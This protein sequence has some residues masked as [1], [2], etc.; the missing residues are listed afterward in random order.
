MAP[1][2]GFPG[3]SSAVTGWP[4][5][6]PDTPVSEVVDGPPAIPPG[7]TATVQPSA[8]RR[9][10]L[11]SDQRIL[12][13]FRQEIRLQGVVGEEKLAATVYLAMTSRLLDDPT[14]L[15]VKG[16]SSS[17]KSFTVQ[18]TA[19][20]FPRSAL[21]EMTAMSERALVY[22]KEPFAHRTIVLYEATA[23][24][25][26]AEKESNLTAYFVRS[27]LS[28]GH[29]EYPVT[30]RDKEGGWTTKTIT[31][32]GPT[33]L[34]V[35]TTST[36]LHAEN[37]TR[38]LSL[39]TNDSPEQTRRVMRQLARGVSGAVDLS[40]W[41]R[42]QE[43]LAGAE[44]RVTVPFAEYLAEQIP[45]VAVRLRRD[46]GSVLSLIKAHAVLHQLHRDRDS[47]GWIV[48]SEEDYQAVRDLISEVLSDGVEATVSQ[49]LRET[50]DAVAALALQPGGIEGIQV[51]AIAERLGLDKSAASRRVKAARERGYLV[52][53]EDR[54]GHP[55]RYVVGDPLPEDVELLPATCNPP[56]SRTAG[57]EGSC[58]VARGAEGI[59]ERA[60]E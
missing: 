19:R 22:M 41:H 39:Q 49:T 44:H 36:R 18:R 57:Q 29:L 2:R 5:F 58:T 24:R 8:A 30:V 55:G 47:E 54:R 45:P 59:D 10:D 13:R 31:K 15:A 51:T 4:G 16:T 7:P 56:P 33:N 25:E 40:E 1:A 48:A 23:L 3:G 11:A 60:A 52:N 32:D 53:L 14:S 28:E 6:E 17:G 34:V 26:G 42:L 43:W 27:L 46:F 21:I 9:P 37:E 35:T 20:F 38:V 50:V 12:D